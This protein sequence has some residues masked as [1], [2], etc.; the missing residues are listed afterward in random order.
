[1][2]LQVNN[3]I[4]GYGKSVIISDL[5]LYVDREEIVT[6]IG[7]NG[8]GKTT[9]MKTILGYIKPF[10]GEILFEKRKLGGLK[11][12]VI[13]KHGIGYVPQLNN[14]FQSMTII[15]NLEM[16]AFLQ[17][18]DRYTLKEL[19]EIFPALKGREKSKARTLSGGER[20][21]LALARAMI[22]KPKLMCLDEPTAAL[23]PKLVNEILKKLVEIRDLG[24][25]IVLI[26]QNAKQSLKI[27]DRGYVLAVGK[28]VHEGPSETLLN[29]PKIQ[30]HYLGIKSI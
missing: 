17:S 1:M 18:K 6:I 5:S 3:V 19:L 7:P 14:V 22:N 2:F 9:L 12:N 16:G 10:S 30:E 4:S 11:P 8:S 27:G 29:S 21:M 15:E 20:Q 26:E 25:T 23:A 13:A 28:K 24:T